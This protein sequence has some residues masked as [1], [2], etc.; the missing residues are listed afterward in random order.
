MP[1]SPPDQIPAVT[2]HLLQLVGRLLHSLSVVAVHHEDKTLWEKPGWSRQLAQ[3]KEAPP[4]PRG[5]QPCYPPAPHPIHPQ[6]TR[7][8]QGRC[9]TSPLARSSARPLC[10]T[11]LRWGDGAN[12][13]APS[14][15]PQR[16]H[17]TRDQDAFPATTHTPSSGR[18][19]PQAPGKLEPAPL[20]LMKFIPALSQR[21]CVFWK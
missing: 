20:Q 15:H 4:Q 21:T 19:R 6:K 5:Q 16:G 13:Q 7:P 11:P 18:I 8:P 14:Q 9:Y 17:R 12:T 1:T 3:R 2:H 10:L